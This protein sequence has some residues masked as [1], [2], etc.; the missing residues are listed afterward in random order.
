MT[1]NPEFKRHAAL[2][3]EL[4]G[5]RGNATVPEGQGGHVFVDGTLFRIKELTSVIHAKAAF[6]YGVNEKEL[7]QLCATVDVAV[8]GFEGLR[9]TTIAPIAQMPR[10]RG[11]DLSWVQKLADIRPLAGMPLTVL[12]LDDIRHLHDLGPLAGLPKLA[13][14]SIEGGMNSTQK[15]ETL[16]PLQELPALRELRLTSLQTDRDGLRP[17]AQ[18]DALQELHLPNNFDTADYAFLRAKCPDLRSNALCAVQ[19]LD[20]A[21]FGKDCMVTGR[22]KPFLNTKTDGARIAKY[23]AAFDALIDGFTQG[24]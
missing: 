18:C 7:E 4:T 10:L 16:A 13:A 12:R 17:L 21:S 24:A 1:A 14:L 6:A 2:S 11:L 9:T 8:L 5:A 23:E 20:H 15:V 19:Y 22:R 3:V